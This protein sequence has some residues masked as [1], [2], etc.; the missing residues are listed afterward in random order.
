MAFI[1]TVVWLS[2]SSPVSWGVPNILNS[3]VD[4]LRAVR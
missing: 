3:S 2:H 1:V 4:E